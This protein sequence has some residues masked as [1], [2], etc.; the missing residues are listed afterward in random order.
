MLLGSALPPALGSREVYEKPSPFT[1]NQSLTSVLFRSTANQFRIN[2]VAFRRIWM[3]LNPRYLAISRDIPP[4][5][6]I[7][8]H[9][10]I[11]KKITELVI[12][13][14]QFQYWLNCAAARSIFLPNVKSRSRSSGCLYLVGGLYLSAQ[15]AAQ[16]AGKTEDARTEQQN[17]ARLR[18][19]AGVGAA[20]REGFPAGSAITKI[21]AALPEVAS[22]RTTS[23]AVW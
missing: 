6:A 4:Y 13:E 18:S 15:L 16:N 11:N 23:T 19:G 8:R 5:P 12:A 14:I 17:A 21:G 20:Q 7:S 10:N 3:R 1:K 22:G 9:C 2:K